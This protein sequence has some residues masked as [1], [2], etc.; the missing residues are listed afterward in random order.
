MAS[1]ALLS[2][3]RPGPLD[4]EAT[5]GSITVTGGDRSDV[6]VEERI[7]FEDAA[8]EDV[9]EYLSENPTSYET[10]NGTVHICG[11]ES[12]DDGRWDG[13]DPDVQYRYTVQVPR[14]FSAKL[15]TSGGSI[16]IEHG[17]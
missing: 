1:A 8:R 17:Q 3:P 5:N 7:R 15:A 6:R 2:C 14:R 4:L 9:T 12:S 13:A 11:P 10:T 16:R